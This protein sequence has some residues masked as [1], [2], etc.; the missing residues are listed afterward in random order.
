MCVRLTRKPVFNGLSSK[1]SLDEKVSNG[2]ISIRS[3]NS[4]KG[5]REVA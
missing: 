5:W 3:G 2:R 1:A 4:S